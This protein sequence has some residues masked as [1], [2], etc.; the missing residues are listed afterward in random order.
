MKKGFKHIETTRDVQF[1]DGQDS[2]SYLSSAPIVTDSTLAPKFARKYERQGFRDI[3]A[4]EFYD[5]LRRFRGWK[6][7]GTPA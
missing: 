3:K 5:S 2:R 7:Y 4:V 1:N 6:I